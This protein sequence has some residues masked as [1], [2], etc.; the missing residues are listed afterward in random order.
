VVALDLLVEQIMVLELQD[1]ETVVG[2]VM[3]TELLQIEMLAAV[4]VQ[5]LL[6]ETPP[7]VLEVTVEQVQRLQF[8]VHQ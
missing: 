5:A 3:I 6:V 7:M 4:A 8:Q 1:K 2:L